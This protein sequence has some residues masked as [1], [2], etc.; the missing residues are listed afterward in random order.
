MPNL[1]RPGDSAADNPYLQ[2]AQSHKY[3]SSLICSIAELEPGIFAVYQFAAVL[4]VGPDWD[5]ALV[6]YQQRPP[7][8]RATYRPPASPVRRGSRSGGKS[9]TADKAANTARLLAALSGAKA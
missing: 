2:L 3:D 8:V 4:Y 5:E 7:Y 6:A 9:S 1:I